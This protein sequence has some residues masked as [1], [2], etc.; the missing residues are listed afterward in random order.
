[1]DGQKHKHMDY[2]Q[3]RTT[4]DTWRTVTVVVVAVCITMIA[5]VPALLVPEAIREWYTTLEHP[6]F[7]PPNGLFA[8][9]WMALYW[10]M[11]IAAGLVWATQNNAAVRGALVLYGMQLMLNAAWTLFFFGLHAPLGALVVIL[12]LLAL[13]I[14]TVRTFFPIH[15]TAGWLLVPYLLWVAF[16]TVLNAAYVWLN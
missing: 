10:M 6:S 14:L 1:M 12:V 13:I 16:A 3:S 2:T 8:P 5:A 9:V 7:A 4:Q 11:G 15:R